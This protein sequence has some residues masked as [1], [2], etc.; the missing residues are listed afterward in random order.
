MGYKPA[1][2]PENKRYPGKSGQDRQPWTTCAIVHSVHTV[3]TVHSSLREQQLSMSDRLRYRVIIDWH[4]GF[5]P[6]V[7]CDVSTRVM[8][9]KRPVLG[10]GTN[11]CQ[12]DT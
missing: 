8:P 2:R 1:V 12:W 6:C 3:H 11:A 7:T 5:D 9:Q 10:T 4:N